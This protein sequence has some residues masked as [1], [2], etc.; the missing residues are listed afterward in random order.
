[1]RAEYL[2]LQEVGGLTVINAMLNQANVIQDLKFHQEQFAYNLQSDFK[3]NLMQT[4]HAFKVSE[5]QETQI[6]QVPVP[7]NE[8]N[9]L[10]MQQMLF[11]QNNQNIPGLSQ[12]M[13]KINA[14][15]THI[16]DLT[17]AASKYDRSKKKTAN[18]LINP[19]INKERKQYYWSSGCCPHWIKYCI[20]KKR[21]HTNDATFR[22]RMGGS[23]G[24][25]L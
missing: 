15:Q 11:A 13:K 7:Q 23:D 10:Q 21:G 18:P 4:L 8:T 14:M 24:K 25:C 19:K 12:L 3:A 5:D 6:P 17:H 1:M 20:T 22:K 9:D 16:Q 2:N